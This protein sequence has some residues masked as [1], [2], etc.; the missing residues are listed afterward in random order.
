M[1]CSQPPSLVVSA[2]NQRPLSTRGLSG[3]MDTVLHIEAFNLINIV[4]ENHSHADAHLSWSVFDQKPDK[5]FDTQEA[6]VRVLS[7]SDSS[8]ETQLPKSLIRELWACSDTNRAP[9]KPCCLQ[10]L[11]SKNKIVLVKEGG[12]TLC[13]VKAFHTDFLSGSGSSP[14]I[15]DSVL[16]ASLRTTRGADRPPD[17]QQE[18]PEIS[19]G[20]PISLNS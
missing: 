9:W 18:R 19:Y 10:S 4:R 7:G 1:W 5:R 6:T 15:T 2:L 13:P 16:Q 12:V 14:V 20:G 3:S 17:W 8:G 11:K